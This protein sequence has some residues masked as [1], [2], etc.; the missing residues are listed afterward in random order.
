[1]Q[2]SIKKNGSALVGLPLMFF[3]PGGV[4]GVYNLSSAVMPVVAGD[5]FEV[6]LN[7]QSD[8]SVT[9]VGN[10]NTWFHLRRIPS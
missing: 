9:V 5:Y 8:T 6:F 3:V 4:I 1:M 10:N 7:I 2:V